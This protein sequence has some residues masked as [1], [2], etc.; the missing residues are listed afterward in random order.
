MAKMMKPEVKAVRFG[1]ADVI[2]TS[3]LSAG[4]NYITKG[5]E[6]GEAGHAAY[7]KY[8]WVVFLYNNNTAGIGK[9]F[10]S[11]GDVTKEYAALNYAWYDYNGNSWKT[12]GTPWY[13][14][15][16]NNVEFPTGSNRS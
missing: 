14:Y 2:A 3:A 1:S 15:Y 13:S 7:S 8:E 6:V 5:S 4:K 16:N 10:D 9:T 12:E 11:D